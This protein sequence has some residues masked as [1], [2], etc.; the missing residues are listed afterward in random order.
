MESR[1]GS[2]ARRPTEEEGRV[3]HQR[4]ERAEALAEPAE[5]ELQVYEEV[6][7]YRRIWNL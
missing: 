1:A 7:L 5:A 2:D 6:T 3:L 4:A